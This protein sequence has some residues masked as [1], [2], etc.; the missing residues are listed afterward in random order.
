MKS[1]LFIK[2]VELLEL[3]RELFLNSLDKGDEFTLIGRPYHTGVF[4][5]RDYDGLE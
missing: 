1:Q 2:V 3:A 5:E 4:G